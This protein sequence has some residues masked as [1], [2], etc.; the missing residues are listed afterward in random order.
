MDRLGAKTFM[1]ASDYP[2]SDT[3][4]DRVANTKALEA[5]RTE[6][7]NAILGENA[8]RFYKI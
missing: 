2:H 4:W 1:Y 7:K 6:E 3:E 8:A 5:L